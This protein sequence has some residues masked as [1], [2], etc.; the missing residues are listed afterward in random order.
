MERFLY[1]RVCVDVKLD[2][3]LP[4]KIFLSNH[5]TSEEDP[6]VEIEM[7]SPE[8][9]KRIRLSARNVMY[10]QSGMLPASDPWKTEY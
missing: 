10:A 1:S 3:V 4:S 5:S 2:A 9:S 8:I 6:V 7:E